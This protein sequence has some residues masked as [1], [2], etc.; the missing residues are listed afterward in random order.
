MKAITEISI[1]Q[2]DTVTGGTAAS[3]GRWVN[4]SAGW[5]V[6]L[7][8]GNKVLITSATGAHQLS[9]VPSGTRR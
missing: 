7:L 2:L 8:E 3:H 4:K 5:A 1:E 6:N 9:A